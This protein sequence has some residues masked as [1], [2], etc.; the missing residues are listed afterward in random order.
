MP[1]SQR[2]ALG[3]SA[4]YTSYRL[5][6][7]IPMRDGHM[8]RIIVLKPS[9]STMTAEQAAGLPVLVMFHGGGECVSYPESEIP[10]LRRLVTKFNMICVAPCF[11]PPRSRTSIPSQHQRRLGHAPV[12]RIR[13]KFGLHCRLVSSTPRRPQSWVQCGRQLR[14]RELR[15]LPRPPR[16]RQ[17]PP[18]TSH[19]PLP[20]CVNVH[21]PQARARQIPALLPLLGTE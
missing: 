8:S 3:R 2:C 13:I 19:Q 9:N 7:S 10:V 21:A 17:Q 15:R 6:Y 4:C 20:L 16:P 11:V 5:R 1:S 14:W 18:A 12:C